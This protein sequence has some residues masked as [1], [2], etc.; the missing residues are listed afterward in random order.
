MNFLMDFED[1]EFFY[2]IGNVV[3]IDVL[4]EVLDNV[5]IMSDISPELYMMILK[6]K[7][8]LYPR[9]WMMG[10]RVLEKY[11]AEVTLR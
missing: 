1:D 6:K 3:N 11:P 9:L 8:T 4:D 7:N 10:M 2:D 5:C